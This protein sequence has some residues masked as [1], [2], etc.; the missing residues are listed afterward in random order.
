MRHFI[1][2]NVDRLSCLFSKEPSTSRGREYNSRYRNEQDD[3]S[4]VTRPAGFD[5]KGFFAS[6]II[7]LLFRNAIIFIEIGREGSKIALQ[8]NYLELVRKNEEHLM[9]YRVNFTPEIEHKGLRFALVRVHEAVIGKYTFDGEH[10]FCPKRLP[11]V[12]NPALD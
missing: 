1:R 4:I 3:I 6:N 5:K 7:I 2:A 11:Q 10:L 9:Q 12:I 8:S